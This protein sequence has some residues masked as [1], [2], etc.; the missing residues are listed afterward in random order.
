[1]LPVNTQRILCPNPSRTGRVDG[2]FGALANPSI[3]VYSVDVIDEDKEIYPFSHS[4]SARFVV[5]LV[6][7]AKKF[8]GTTL[9]WYVF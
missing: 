9:D 5:A 1:M 8:S 2:Y 7:K 3:I 6:E 4:H